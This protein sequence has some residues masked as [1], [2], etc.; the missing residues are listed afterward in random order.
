M[1]EALNSSSQTSVTPAA[2]P[3]AQPAA[4]A[5]VAQPVAAQPA[6]QPT[7][8]VTPSSESG[9]GVGGGDNIM[10]ILKNLNWIEILFGALGV[11]VLFTAADYYRNNKNKVNPSLTD[12]YNKM[13]K[14]TIELSDVKTALQNETTNTATKNTQGFV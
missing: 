13:D 4:P 12:I 8:T 7:Y 9:G 10:E 3:A 2:Q 5:A 6:A 11:Y 1:E 14:I